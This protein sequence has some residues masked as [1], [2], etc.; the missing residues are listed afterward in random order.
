MEDYRILDWDSDFFGFKVVRINP[1]RLDG[2]QLSEIISHLRS[3]NVTLVY[4]PSRKDGGRVGDGAI[5]R[6]GGYL[7]DEKITFVLELDDFDAVQSGAA[8]VVERYDSTMAVSDLES[9]AIQSGEHSRFAVDPNIPREKFRE[10]Y[11]SWIRKC[12]TR[13]LADQVLVIRAGGSVVGMVTLGGRNDRGNIGLIAVD[14]SSR[15]RGYGLALVRA[16][17]VWFIGKDYASAQVVT[18]GRNV[19]ACNLYRKCGYCVEKVEHYY[20]FWLRG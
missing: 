5:G 20:H 19:S 7:V 3:H 1:S 2:E 13:E 18:Q 15:G 17:Q 4:W 12:L 9:L 16:A 11:R 8:A 14:Q 10:L 6:L